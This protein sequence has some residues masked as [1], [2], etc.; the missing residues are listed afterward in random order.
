MKYKETFKIIKNLEFDKEK[1]ICKE[2]GIEIFI[3]RPSK[4]SKRFKDYDVKKNFQIW[5][6]E[7]ERV[8]RPNHLRIMIDL[9][10]RVRSRPD[11]KKGLLLI[12][13]NIF[14][15]NDPDLEIK[16]IENE[17][18]EH[19]LNPLRII[20]NLAQLFIIEQEYGYPGESNYDPGTLFLQGWIREFI[21][22]PK[23]IDNLCMSVCRPQPP[24][25]Q[26]T[27]KENKKHKNYEKNLKPLWYLK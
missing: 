19:F 26:Y 21:D 22:S 20:A 6:R 1:I 24:K 10:L 15:G 16:R 17:N 27:S 25:T 14:Y 23:E 18:F 3:L 7:G 2:K 13:D 11:L 12:F 8:F 9:N 4:L 5:L